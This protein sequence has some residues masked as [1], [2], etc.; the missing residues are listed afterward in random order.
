MI[1]KL[2]RRELF[3]P[4]CLGILFGLIYFKLP[5]KLFTFLFI[6]MLVAILTLYNIK[7]GI[8]ISIFA[9]PYMPDILNLLFM[10][11]I[12]FAFIYRGIFRKINPL[13]KD[14]IDV[15]IAIFVLVIIMSTITSVSPGGSFRDLALHLIS[16]SF[17]FVIINTINDK[18]D[19]NNIFVVL[20]MTGTLV[21]LYGIYQ[22]N[23]KIDM[24]A[25]WL[26]AANN[27]GITTRVFSV[28]GNPN[29]L[30]EYLVMITPIS[31]AMFWS[32]KKMYKKFIFLITSLILVASLVLTFSRGGWLGF[33]IGMLIF[34]FL[35][36]KRLLLLLIPVA[37]IAVN[38][39][40]SSIVNR[41]TSIKNLSDSSNSY[42]IRLWK[43][44]LELIR[45]NLPIGVGFGHLPFK[46]IFETYTRAMPTYHSHNTYLQVMAEMGIIGIVVLFTFIIVF[47][48][49]S[50]KELI[51][52]EDK[53]VK[54]MTAGIISGLGAIFVHGVVENIFYMPKIIT[55]FW[56][57][58]S[59]ILV[60]IRIPKNPEE[61]S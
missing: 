2:K 21:A 60:L 9:Y 24:E 39:L 23:I 6:G 57:L 4:I 49:Y 29:I 27:E 14:P 45:D 11:F 28:F 12:F 38:F 16:I 52:E 50:I 26:D 32:S 54:T 5:L 13:T 42:R 7:I 17:V 10:I 44:T 30:A 59:F 19:L 46:K 31:V 61:I 35:V 22:Y 20:V 8:I 37:L 55:T 56:I 58:V 36:E 51:K 34:I 33:A 41:I 40:P 15:P 18:E 48:K 53:W 25:K 47:Y 43:I 1:E 3:L